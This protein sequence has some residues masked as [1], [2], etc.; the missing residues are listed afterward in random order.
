MSTLVH[1]FKVGDRVAYI[2]ERHHGNAN[3]VGRIHYVSKVFWSAEYKTFM[4]DILGVE[5]K[6]RGGPS[7]PTGCFR[8]V[9][10]AGSVTA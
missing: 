2:H 9:S 1:P 7:F 10:R 6:M 4:V 3:V 8:L 5:N